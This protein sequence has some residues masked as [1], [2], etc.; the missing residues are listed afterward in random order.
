[1]ESVLIELMERGSA[2]VLKSRALQEAINSQACRGILLLL[3]LQLESGH[4]QFLPLRSTSL[5]LKST[6]TQ[7][8][9]FLMDLINVYFVKLTEFVCLTCSTN[10]SELCNIV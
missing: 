10:G 6:A 7:N 8:I 9:Y 4:F 3:L 1:M 5:I 2:A